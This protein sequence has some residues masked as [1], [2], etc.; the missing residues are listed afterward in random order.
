MT[1]PIVVVGD[2][3]IDVVVVPDGPLAHGSDTPS[4]IRTIGGGSAANTACWL[5]SL[6]RDV[7]LVAAVGDDALGQSALAELEATG[8]RFVGHVDRERSTGTCVVLVDPHGERTMLPDRGANDAL[9]PA[10]V[11]AALAGDPAWL[12]LSGYALLGAGSHPAALTALATASRTETPW[13]LDASS[14]APLRAIGPTRFLSWI[15]GCEVLFAN[16]DELAVLGGAGPVLA[17][18][19]QLVAKHGAAGAS[20][21]D[22]TRSASAT[23]LDVPVVDTIG[24]GDA[25]DAGYL[26]AILSGAETV[27]ALHAGCRLA[28]HAIAH[29]G[30][31]PRT[32]AQPP[33]AG[34]APV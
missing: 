11:A 3:M 13:S 19:T 32:T 22:G 5:A 28:A 26:D 29:A 18:A 7:S 9:P 2:L 21:T 23:A 33:A 1:A 24:A 8:V 12:H 17:Q 27:D 6:G 25:F 15:H 30:A 16:D 31:R 20:W 14:A 4:A 10:S 34:S